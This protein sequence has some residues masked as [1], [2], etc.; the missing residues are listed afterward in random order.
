MSNEFIYLLPLWIIVFGSLLIL[1]IEMFFHENGRKIIPS[2]SVLILLTA[3]V[4]EVYNYIQHKKFSVE[5]L[6][7]HETAKIAI[8]THIFILGSLFSGLL[9]VLFSEQYLKE[10]RASTGEYYAIV[11]VVV[12]GM[13]NLIVADEFLTFFVGLELMSIGGYILTAYIRTKE[14]SIE[15]AIKYY[16]P[17]VFSTGFI[18]M[19]IAFVYGISGTTFFEHIK[20]Q[21]PQKS[22]SIYLFLIGIVFILIGLS[23][24]I[25]LVPFHAYAPDVYEGASAPISAF[26]STGIKIAAFASMIRILGESFL[27]E[28]DWNQILPLLSLATMIVGNVLAFNQENVKRMLA[29]SSIAHAGYVLLAIITLQ[30]ANL[31]DIYFS[32]GFYLFAYTFMTAGSFGLLGY[33]SR[34]EEKYTNI[35]DFTGFAKDHPW[36][37]IAMAVFMFSLIGFPPTAGFFGKYYVFRLALQEGYIFLVVVGIINSFLSAYYYLR[38]V[39]YMFMKK[40][41]SIELNPMLPTLKWGVALS[42]IGTVVLGFVPFFY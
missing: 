16:L 15:A 20:F 42:V 31:S 40:E 5:I 4:I 35:Q 36:L 38:V 27:M 3:I 19:G 13:I 28:G 6:L 12:S 29:Y 10:Q 25:A 8:S 11:L 30:K 21:L 37:S 1:L 39:V 17:G 18:L 9:T 26:L 22:H 24:K 32:V 23:F 34:K 14:I 41:E 33:L 7:F 2:F